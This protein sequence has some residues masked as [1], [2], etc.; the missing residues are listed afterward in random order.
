M[1]GLRVL[2]AVMGVAL[3]VTSC[4][5][6][7]SAAPTS[8]TT[9]TLPA[10]P[11][12]PTAPPVTT[13]FTGWDFNG[14]VWRPL[15]TP[16]ACAN[17]LTLPLPVEMSRVTSILYPGQVRGDYKAHGGFRFDLPGQT[18]A[19]EVRATMPATLLRAGRYLASGEIQYTF[20]FVND[21]GIMFRF[22]HLRDLPP[23]F[24]AIADTLPAPVELDSR[25]TPISGVTVTLG[26]VLGTGVG[27]R[28]SARNVFF[29]YGVYDL[30]QRNASSNDPAWLAAHDN[31][32]MPY[33]ICWFDTLS[34]ADAALVRSLPPA[35]GVMGRTS[36]YCR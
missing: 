36:D 23:K 29:D 35:D 9:T 1:N 8:P 14:Q 22:G 18:T 5:G 26:E 10:T 13:T 3:A 4:G 19:V 7:S 20:D 32:I 31:D 17:P 27:L 24:Q 2:S 6:G 16:P 11:T 28:D 33:G 25:S 15:G 12:T 34:A 21:C 30:R